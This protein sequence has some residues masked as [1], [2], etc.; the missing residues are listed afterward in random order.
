VIMKKPT[1]FVYHYIVHKEKL[2]PYVDVDKL[3]TSIVYYVQNHSVYF[4]YS[5]NFVDDVMVFGIVGHTQ[6]HLELQKKLGN[7][8]KELGCILKFSTFHKFG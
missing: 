1:D 3:I 4:N 6:D 5:P 2:N 7:I 8:L